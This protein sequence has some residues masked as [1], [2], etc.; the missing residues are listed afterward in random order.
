VVAAALT[1]CSDPLGP[2]VEHVAVLVTLSRSE[3]MVGDTAEVRV[4]ARNPTR[5]V[6]T[7]YTNACVLGVR[8]LDPSGQV[9]HQ[10][11][12]ACNDIGLRHELA[13][14]ESLEQ[15]FRFDG[16][17]TWGRAPEGIPV[18]FWV[19]PGTYDVIGGISTNFFSPSPPVELRI[20]P[21]S[22]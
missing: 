15:T 4:V 14:G 19:P 13:P 8:L 18:R 1:A 17:T 3:M 10:D 6:L 9:V 16:T 21:S 2:D 22:P 12:V 11:P 5:R 7:F 20:L